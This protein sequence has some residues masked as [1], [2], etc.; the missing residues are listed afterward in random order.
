MNTE[1]LK[2]LII[3]GT[4][5]LLTG[6]FGVVLAIFRYRQSTGKDALATTYARIKA[7]KAE[8]EAKAQLPSGRG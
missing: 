8:A 7:T 2:T 6:G 3:C 5:V 1:I 4:I